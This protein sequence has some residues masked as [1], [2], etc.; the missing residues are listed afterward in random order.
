MFYGYAT[1][2]WLHAIHHWRHILLIKDYKTIYILFWYTITKFRNNYRYIFNIN[3]ITNQNKS[4]DK[5]SK[6]YGCLNVFTICLQDSMQTCCSTN[7]LCT[8][9]PTKILSLGQPFYILCHYYYYCC[10]GIY[11][12][13]MVINIIIYY[14]R[15]LR[16]NDNIIITSNIFFWQILSS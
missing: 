10:S 16:L 3:W 14:Y 1:G 8:R 9:F 2:L 6:E 5:I 7:R 11:G 4:L 12:T 13:I 15:Y